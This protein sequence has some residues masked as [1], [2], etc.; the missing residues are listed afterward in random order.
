MSTRIICLGHATMDRI[1]PVSQLPA[2]GGK[3][4][5]SDYLETG[6]GMAANAAVT[7]ARLGGTVDYWGRAGDDA[8]GDAMKKEMRS[9]GVDVTHFRLYPGARSSTSAILVTEDGER[10][11]IN[12][13][14]ADIPDDPA[15]LPLPLV[16]DAKAVLADFRWI[17]GACA[18][19]KAA[20]AHGV[21]TVLDAESAADE[22]FAATLPLADHAVF[23][24][25]GLGAFAGAPL[26]SDADHAAALTKARMSGCRV[27][28]VTRGGNGVIW[29]DETGIHHQ[30]SCKVNA[31]DTTGA[32]DAFHGAYV[33]A[34]GEGANVADAMR[35]ASA[36]AALKC[37]RPGSR[38]GLPDRE[39]VIAFL[40]RQEQE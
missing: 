19:F 30:A 23:S 38:A 16:R 24:E 18:L 32:G 17:E 9:Y 15:W 1:W 20:R 12:F 14:G 21:T 4:R 11:I 39:E 34:I 10:A 40:A 26:E 7:V 3:Y 25:P 28:A 22:V 6:G 36:V 31:V 2:T 5:A 13:R 27:V 37:T 35:F 29:I 8:A 33:L